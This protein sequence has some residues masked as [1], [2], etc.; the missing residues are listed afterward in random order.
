MEYP[1]LTVGNERSVLWLCEEM[2][3]FAQEAWALRGVEEKLGVGGAFED[4][5]FFGL[6]S[7]FVV[8]G[9]AGQAWAVA[10]Y[11]VAGEDEELAAGEFFRCVSA[12]G[13][14]DDD[15]VEGA[16]RR[17]GVGVANGI[18]TEAAADGGYGFRT[19][20]AEVGDGG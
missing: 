14:E 10:A 13:G 17:L 8:A 5:Q 18:S 2:K 1:D 7:L 19:N 6:L 15:A 4:D 9:D 20:A 11:I 16:G 3:D 12:L